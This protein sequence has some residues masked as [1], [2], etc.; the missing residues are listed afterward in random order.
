MSYNMQSTWDCA[1]CTV[2]G[3]LILNSHQG[4]GRLGDQNILAGEENYEATATSR[5]EQGYLL[6]SKSACLGE[7]KRHEY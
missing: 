5:S 2:Q 6:W 7:R 4:S 1:C 3:S